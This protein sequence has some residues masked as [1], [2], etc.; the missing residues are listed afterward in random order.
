MASY[1]VTLLTPSGEY[2][3]ACPDDKYILDQAEEQGIHL[4]YSC[5]VGACSSDAAILKSGS[6]DQS[7]QSFLDDDQMMCGFVLLSVAY[8][9]SDCVILTHQED[10]LSDQGCGGGGINLNPVVVNNN[11]TNPVVN[12][13]WSGVGVVYYNGGSI[14]APSP[15][16]IIDQ[17]KGKENCLNTLLNKQGNSFVQKLLA[18]FQGKSEFDIVIVS[19]DKITSV[20][21]GV[22]REINGQTIHVINT[23]VITIQISTSRTNE[24]SALEATRTILHEYIHADIYRKLLTKSNDIG[25]RASDFKEVYDKYGNDHNNMANLYLNSMTTALKEFHK[26]VLTNDYNAYVRNFGE[27]PTDSFYRALAWNGLK[28]NDVKAWV[29]LSQVEKD[30]I[31][32]MSVRANQLGKTVPCSN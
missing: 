31:Q 32:R 22:A 8:P 14:S 26:N 28:D 29:D 6:V 23:K 24:H 16:Q 3:I 15:Y 4:P 21:N 19:R 7:D 11:Y 18:N 25:N 12:I 9:T 17:L 30:E 1:K 10:K 5:R 20:K 27:E 2:T 13:G